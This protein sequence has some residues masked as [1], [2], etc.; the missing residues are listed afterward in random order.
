MTIPALRI[1]IKLKVASFPRSI[2]IVELRYLTGIME[3]TDLFYR[4]SIEVG[5]IPSD[6]SNMLQPLDFLLFGL[7]KQLFPT[8]NRLDSC[9]IQAKGISMIIG[10]F[11]AVT[12]SRNIINSLRDTRICLI[13]DSGS[14]LR[15]GQ[16][17][18]AGSR[19]SWTSEASELIISQYPDEDVPSEGSAGGT[20]NQ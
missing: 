5:E 13:I 7:I 14:L 9:S 10:S 11:L 15:V 1:M 19:F 18:C 6:S 3:S 17:R 12:S 16:S 2:P 8:A 4:P 20:G